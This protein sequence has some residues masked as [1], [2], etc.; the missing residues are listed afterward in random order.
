M[1]RAGATE[2][3]QENSVYILSDESK[4]TVDLLAHSAYSVSGKLASQPA[5]H[6]S[7]LMSGIV[8]NNGH[9]P[10]ETSA[11]DVVWELSN[12]YYQATVA[13]QSASIDDGKAKAMGSP[14][15]IVLARDHSSVRDMPPACQLFPKLL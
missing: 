1:S 10:A 7:A 4:E 2:A 3:K 11:R 5:D 14:A 9:E 15:V 6:S 12:K 13:F 8:S